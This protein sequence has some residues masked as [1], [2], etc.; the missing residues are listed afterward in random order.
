MFKIKSKVKWCG[1]K[2][3]ILD[4]VNLPINEYYN[5][6]QQAKYKVQD[7][8]MSKFPTFAPPFWVWEDELKSI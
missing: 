1:M 5:N 6:R 4:R 2:V 8:S 7:V 3:K